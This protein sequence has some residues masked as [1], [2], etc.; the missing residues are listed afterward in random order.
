MTGQRRRNRS[1]KRRGTP[2]VR[3]RFARVDRNSTE[4]KRRQTKCYRT[5]KIFGFCSHDRVIDSLFV[6]FA[7]YTF[8]S[9]Y[10]LV[11]RGSFSFARRK[12]RG[13]KMRHPR[14]YCS[15][16]GLT[17]CVARDGQRTERSRA[18]VLNRSTFCVHVIETM[19]FDVL[20]KDSG[21]TGSVSRR[22]TTRKTS[23]PRWIT[24]R[25]YML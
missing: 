3:F 9:A 23:L 15:L 12:V 20:S 19:R 25:W 2:V 13:R 7:R 21:V 22:D 6:Q 16:V 5:R 18:T 8:A 24:V 11:G 17:V 14:F 1:G 10:G 4:P